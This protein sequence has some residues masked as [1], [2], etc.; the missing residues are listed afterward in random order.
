MSHFVEV[1]SD[2]HQTWKVASSIN[3]NREDHSVYQPGKAMEFDST[4]GKP[5]KPMEFDNHTWNFMI[6]LFFECKLCE[7]G[8]IIHK[9]FFV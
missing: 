1:L 5:G 9:T 7:K 4:H 8:C 3:H 6:K 2:S